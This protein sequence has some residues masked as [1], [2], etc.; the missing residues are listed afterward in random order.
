MDGHMVTPVQVDEAKQIFSVNLLILEVIE[1]A[2]CVS[3]MLKTM[4]CGVRSLQ[5]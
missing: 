3:V 2:L 4:V 1:L 5:C